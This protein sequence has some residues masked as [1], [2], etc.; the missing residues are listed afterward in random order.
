MAAA[1][2]G[3]ARGKK[4]TW[5]LT[6]PHCPL[7]KE[8]VLCYL[9]EYV[10]WDEK[11]VH[12]QYMVVAEEEHADGQPHL[13]VFFQTDLPF[14]LKREEMNFFDIVANLELPVLE[15]V[16][17]TNIY[18]CNIEQSRSPKDACKYV[19]KD[20]NY[21]E[22]GTCPYIDTLSR[23]E[24]NELLRKK[25]ILELVEEG[26]ISIFQ[27]KQLK[28]AKDIL[29]L[30]ELGKQKSRKP[31]VHWY[32]GATGTGKTKSARHEAKHKYGLNNT[33]INSTNDKWFDGYTGQEAVIFDDIR[34]STFQFSNMLRLLDRYKTRVEIKGG[35]T[36]F[37]PK[38]IWVT[39]PSHP[40]N[41]YC[42]HATGNP[43]DG[44]E[45]LERRIDDLKEIDHCEHY[46][47]DDEN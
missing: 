9:M 34:A 4:K 46:S 15:A 33:W 28:V 38:E 1:D 18:H 42:D 21:T 39:C 2:Y 41:I 11:H 17:E 30:E 27:V 20:H 3:N 24:K 32:Y 5:L 14:S 35:F 37:C 45:Q 44:I 47:S 19:K 8:S 40:R 22:Y 25:T 36:F 12:V 23:K 16:E 29:H 13:H 6:Y 31:F 43:F 26:T 10:A 7:D